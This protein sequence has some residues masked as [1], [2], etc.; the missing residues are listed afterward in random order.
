LRKMY[1]TRHDSIKIAF[2]L[3]SFKGKAEEVTLI[4]SG[5][6]ENFVNYKTVVRL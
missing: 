5:A 3:Y 4:D 1:I 2:D 6:T